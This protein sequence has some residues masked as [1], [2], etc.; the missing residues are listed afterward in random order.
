MYSLKTG[1]IRKVISVDKKYC[2]QEL[3]II[4][5]VQND[6]TNPIFGKK[7]M[8]QKEIYKICVLGLRGGEEGRLHFDS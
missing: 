8:I 3:C 4:T 7:G 6:A 5:K 1:K 2:P